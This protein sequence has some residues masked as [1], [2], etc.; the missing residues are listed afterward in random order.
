MT[1]AESL[2]T[3]VAA[4]SAPDS[5]ERRRLLTACCAPDVVQTG[6]QLTVTGVDVVAGHLDDYQAATPGTRCTLSK[7]YRTSPQHAV[8]WASIRVA[9]ADGRT[10]IQTS[11]IE[12]DT[13]NRIRRVVVFSG[14]PPA[15]F[16]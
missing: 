1:V 10:F 2:N 9:L 5:A 16:D 6:M 3:Y 7:D 4:L 15:D 12:F 14:D 13:T 8:V 11:I